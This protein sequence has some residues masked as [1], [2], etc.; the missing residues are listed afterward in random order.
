MN[1]KAAEKNTE[2][3]PPEE[4]HL[5]WKSPSRLFKKR[6]K[7]YFTNVAAIVFLLVVILVFAREYM[8]ILAV[9]SVVF[10]IYVTS[11]VAPEEI[12]HRLTNLGIESG[13]RF[14]RWGEMVDFW[15]EEQWGQVMMVIRSVARGRVMILINPQ[16]K[17]K[18][19]EIVVQYVPFREQPPT[20]W[21]DNASRWISEK[22]PLEKPV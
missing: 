6:N 11:T 21:M 13:G 4:V 8:F 19:R 12:E 3:P 5:T 22:V 14:Y 2:T 17:E 16:D 1:P 10:F 9:L 18:I 15:Y 20:N 7:E